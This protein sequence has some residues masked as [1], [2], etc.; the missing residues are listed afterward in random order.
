MEKK[1]T[2]KEKR[3]GAHLMIP[4]FLLCMIDLMNIKNLK[5][6]IPLP[7]ESREV[8]KQSN[9]RLLHKE[10]A[11]VHLSFC[12][13]K[14]LVK[15]SKTITESSRKSDIGKVEVFYRKPLLTPEGKID[16]ERL[17]SEILFEKWKEC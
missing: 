2:K 10:F 16:F 8:G 6:C 3:Q 5:Q 14:S 12:P 11:D 17:Y 4:L 15:I 1:L 7:R 13:Q 9:R